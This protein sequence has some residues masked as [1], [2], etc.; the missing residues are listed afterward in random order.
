LDLTYTYRAVDREGQITEAT[1]DAGSEEDALR[2]LR[3]RSMTIISLT[4]KE[5]A[6]G[7][8]N[9]P[10][11]KERPKPTDVMVFCKQM[12]VM[13]FAGVPL[14]RALT[15]LAE[16]TDKGSMKDAIGDAARQIKQGIPFSRALRSRPEA[17]PDLLCGMVEAGELTGNIGDVLQRMSVHYEK[18]NRINARIRGAMIYPIILAVLCV[19]VVIVMLVFVFPMFV[20]MFESS[21]TQLPLP[22]RIMLAMSDSLINFW[23][24]HIAVI[25]TA[26][27]AFIRFKNSDFGKKTLDSLFLRMP[28]ISKP[29]KTVITARFTRTLATLMAS[30][31]AIV[32]S[33]EKAT[34]VTANYVLSEEMIMV[35]E[36][37]KQGSAMSDLMRRIPIF[38][39]MMLSMVSVGEESGD[40]DGLLTKTAD[41][42]DEELETAIAKLVSMV[43]PI[44]LIVMAG[45]IG[46][47]LLAM[48][49]PMFEMSS[50]IS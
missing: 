2:M 30:G 42:Y 14:D 31:V 37:V 28:M 23:Y 15:I 18:E 26:A 46:M 16:Q 10:F 25:G 1:I 38:P 44:M 40:L 43:E 22:T 24:I 7:G 5:Y 34:E 50:T 9:L 48:Y 3:A 36:G 21:G 8:L 35:V 13:M 47:I 39:P 11:L 6:S 17:F 45:L 12:S 32:E 49:M 19:V 27:L 29:L 4:L 41:F 33:I 20:G